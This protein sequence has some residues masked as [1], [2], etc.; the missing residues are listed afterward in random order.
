MDN[1]IIKKAINK[2]KDAFIEIMKS[3]EKKLYIIAKLKL[4]NYED[5]KDIIQE[6]IVESYK[7]I[8]Q[9]RE[10]EKFESWITS[11]LINKCNKFYKDQNNYNNIPYD[12]NEP[13]IENHFNIIEDKIDF[14]NLLKLLGNSEK[15]I[16]TLYYVNNY[17]TAEISNILSINE[18]TIKTK[19]RRSREKIK[20]YLERGDKNEF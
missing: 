20:E 10:P 2:D 6:T 1:N 14:F 5:I 16:F 3:V 13:D 19:L 18:N 15:E 7:N 4:N 11:I 9:V 17:T 12:D 8:Q